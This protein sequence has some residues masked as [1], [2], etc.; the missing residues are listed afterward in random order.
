[1][2]H[3]TL[4]KK[5]QF[6]RA[7]V[8]PIHES[9][10]DW[11]IVIR[12]AQEEG[13]NLDEELRQELEEVR[14][15]LV[16]VIPGRFHPY[17]HDYTL[18][19]PALAK[20]V[21]DDYLDWMKKQAGLFE[22][23]LD[24]AREGREEAVP[25][26]PQHAQEVFRDSLHDG[27]VT[28][29]ERTGNDLALM[30]GMEG[31]FTSKAIIVLKFVNIVSEEGSVEI[32]SYYV[33]D[34]LR[35]ADKGVALRVIFDCPEMQWTVECETIEAAYYFRPVAYLERDEDM[36]LQEYVESL[37]P[38]YRHVFI[39][40]AIVPWNLEIPQ[41]K[42]DG[43]YV[44]GIKVAETREECIERIF[45]DTYEDPYAVFSIPLPQEELEEAALGSDL[46]LQVRAFNTLYADP[47]AN[48]EVINR[49]FRKITVHEENEM[50]ISVMVGHFGELG[51]LD[52]EIMAKFDELSE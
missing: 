10:D 32:G 3:L 22:N 51:L 34:E 40:D 1:M 11:A 5:R 28:N 50:V 16:A 6:E 20:E 8:L 48:K 4:E 47:M 45:C 15:E 35:R 21:R 42:D 36:D 37:N 31:G 39:T 12:E 44:G 29:T 13:R 7:S 25:L 38:A 27:V 30:F 26:L 52:E 19:T 17:V 2:W 18:N 24:K 33:Y 41:R 43:F 9:D 46:E 49:I 23:V 14:D